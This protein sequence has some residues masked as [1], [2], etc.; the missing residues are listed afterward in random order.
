MMTTKKKK[1]DLN[2]M[3][4]ALETSNQKIC[5]QENKHVQNDWYDTQNGETQ[6]ISYGL[7]KWVPHTHNYK[8]S[9]VERCLKSTKC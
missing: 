6:C 2:A 4:P 8:I 9:K 1:K 3:K 7:K 5:K